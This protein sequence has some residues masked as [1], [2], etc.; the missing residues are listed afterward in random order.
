MN[1]TSIT[2]FGTH[3][4]A[5]SILQGLIDDPAFDVSKV[6]TQPD[7]PV[8]RK[9][10]LTP[11][12]VKNLALS[13]GIAIESPNSLKNFDVSAFDTPL[14]VVAQYGKIIPQAILDAF[15]KGVI[16]VHTSLL[17]KYRGAS[18]IQSA[19]IDGAGKTGVT[20]MQM[21]AGMDTGPILSKQKVIIDPDI[22]YPELDRQLAI[23][24]S[25]LLCETLPGFLSGEITPKEQDE[26]EATTCSLLSRDDGE[27][28]WQDMNAK[29]VYNRYRG[30]TP[31]PGI[32]T[33]IHGKRLKLLEIR[34]S[35]TELKPG[36]IQLENKQFLIGCV[37]GSIKVLSA[38]LEGKQ[39]M[40]AETFA[41]GFSGL[42]GHIIH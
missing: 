8:G 41:N 9:K 3:E 33:Q 17:P 13:Y 28:L 5:C 6:V 2:F 21:D 29:Q 39:P 30:L 25:R 32:W 35:K 7:K 22:T 12:P 26:S 36:E 27:I 42:N 20:I 38:Q 31:W 11:S 24:G 34:R 16:N 19:L 37:S 15:A 14:A 1:K 40:D 10:E 23:V 4:F 18:P